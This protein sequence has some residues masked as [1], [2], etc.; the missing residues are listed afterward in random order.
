MNHKIAAIFL[1]LTLA[2][3][4]AEYDRSLYQ[5]QEGTYYEPI[6]QKTTWES[7]LGL[8]SRSLYIYESYSF[9][10]TG[11]SFHSTSF[12]STKP[13]K[14]FLKGY[15]IDLELDWTSKQLHEPGIG[16]IAALYVFGVGVTMGLFSDLEFKDLPFR[17]IKPFFGIKVQ[18]ALNQFVS[19]L[20]Q[21]NAHTGGEATKTSAYLLLGPTVGT[22]LFIIKRT[23]STFISVDYLFDTKM[24]LGESGLGDK[25]INHFAFNLGFNLYIL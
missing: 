19:G 6:R 14:A 20:I 7:A 15:Y 9:I 1:T 25:N 16:N 5:E 11:F 18:Y 13:N 21:K 8:G 10:P 22:E 2:A 23:V 3:F 24:N 4:S 12:L 17:Y